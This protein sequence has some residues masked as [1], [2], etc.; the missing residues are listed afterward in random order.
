M[1]I[2]PISPISIDWQ[3]LRTA[4][5][6]GLWIV[7]GLVLVT[8]L[9]RMRPA[10]PPGSYWRE[11]FPLDVGAFAVVGLSSK[12]L[13]PAIDALDSHLSFLRP[14]A[15]GGWLPL[16]AKVVVVLLVAD[17]LEY[18]LHRAMHSF[19]K[20]G[21][22][23][24]RT[25]VW[26]HAPPALT[27]LAGYRGSF[28]QRLLFGACFLAAAILFDLHEPIGLATIAAISIVHELIIHANVNIGLG[29]LGAVISTPRWHR[30]HHAAEARLQ[31]SNFGM[32]FTIWDRLFGTYTDPDA[33]P[34]DFPLGVSEERHP[35][36]VVVGV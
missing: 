21:E 17:L 23:L 24:W 30:I 9:E 19:S 32:R 26:H 1:P 14:S 8:A 10:R 28:L 4:L 35:V 18:W 20:A 6:D 22:I 36:R 12:V 15:W 3:Q 29:P 16:W 7:P 34:A 13:G 11:R 27:A 5:G 2:S 31:L 25:H 33:V